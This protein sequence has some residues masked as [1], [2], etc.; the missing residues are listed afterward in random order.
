MNGV[1]VLGLIMVKVYI[2]L[3]GLFDVHISWFSFIWVIFWVMYNMR[4]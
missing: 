2:I 1:Q 4:K 3:N